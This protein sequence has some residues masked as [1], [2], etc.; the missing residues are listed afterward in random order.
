M[1]TVWEI[2]KVKNKET[3][4]YKIK[5]SRRELDLWCRTD[6]HDSG[7]LNETRNN[8]VS[9]FGRDGNLFI[10][11]ALMARCRNSL[12]CKLAL[13]S[14]ALTVVGCLTCF[15]FVCVFLFF[16]APPPSG[17][18]IEQSKTGFPYRV[19]PSYRWIRDEI[20]NQCH[21]LRNEK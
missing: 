15:L 11:R 18:F 21:T 2:G 19:P 1:C 20:V 16:S 5:T 12:P 10:I 17:A 3:K 8:F 6:L 9:Q 4:K 13:T 14:L 7:Q